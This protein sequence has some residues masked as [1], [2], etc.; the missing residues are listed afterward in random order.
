[1]P[2]RE[3]PRP[4]VAAASGA[5]RGASAEASVLVQKRANQHALM[6]AR[7]SAVDQAAQAPQRRAP[8]QPLPP[9]RR[10]QPGRAMAPLPGAEPAAER[11]AR[12]RDAR[13]HPALSEPEVCARPAEPAPR[14]RPMPAW[15]FDPVRSPCGVEPRPGT[16]ALEWADPQTPG[17]HPLRL[18]ANR[19]VESLRRFRGPAAMA[20]PPQ[21]SAPEPRSRRLR[22]RRDK[23]PKEAPRKGPR[24][25]AKH[26][27]SPGRAGR[28]QRRGRPSGRA[29]ATTP[30]LPGSRRLS[31]G[32]HPSW[33]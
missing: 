5:Q 18:P 16:L 19:L 27:R 14:G 26:R 2:E 29:A 4:A 11:S 17:L 9:A 15:L 10:R 20:A 23:R 25:A 6:L 1:M 22:A 3:W 7:R 28:T 12:P 33:P 21:G 30:G 8:A 24:W 13:A 32:S 31:S